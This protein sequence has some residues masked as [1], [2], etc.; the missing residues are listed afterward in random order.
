MPIVLLFLALL[1]SFQ[2]RSETRIMLDSFPE[3]ETF[4]IE[5]VDTL[6]VYNYETGKEK[7]VVANSMIECT[8]I[9]DTVSSYTHETTEEKIWVVRDTI[10]IYTYYTMYGSQ[11]CDLVEEYIDAFTETEDYAKD[12]IIVFDAETYEEALSIIPVLDEC[13][14]LSWGSHFFSLKHTVDQKTAKELLKSKINISNSCGETESFACKVVLLEPHKNPGILIIRD[15]DNDL[16]R[17][18]LSK[19]TMKSGSR[20][21]IEDIRVNGKKVLNSMVIKVK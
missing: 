14:H 2:A 6:T 13:Y 4:M 11:R 19:R 20:I 1:L 17:M 16:G 15:T 18:D 12:T 21:L 7:V 8:E 5:R 10:P 3:L 9:V